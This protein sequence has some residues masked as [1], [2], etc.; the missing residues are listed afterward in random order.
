MSEDFDNYTNA[1]EINTP[2]KKVE[3]IDKAISKIVGKDIMTTD[4][5]LIKLITKWKQ[6]DSKADDSEVNNNYLEDEVKIAELKK[7]FI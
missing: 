7:A 3:T 5:R 2:R 4:I 6:E 1:R